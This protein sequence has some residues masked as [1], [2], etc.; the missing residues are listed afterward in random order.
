[1]KKARIRVPAGVRRDVLT[2]SSMRCC[3]CKK[4]G[5]QIHHLDEDPSNNRFDNLVLL[6][7]ECHNEVTARGGV[8]QRADKKTLR[9]MRESW[10]E[11]VQRFGGKVPSVAQDRQV[12]DDP[13]FD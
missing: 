12:H 8:A 4:Q 1:M 3:K 10:Y 13:V 2:K 6:C 11:L 9:V 7:F 5:R